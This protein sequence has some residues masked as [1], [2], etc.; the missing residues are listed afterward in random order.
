V[1]TEGGVWGQT[2]LNE[3]QK[4]ELNKARV[5]RKERTKDYVLNLIY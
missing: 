1:W 3:K 2:V 5:E 4:E